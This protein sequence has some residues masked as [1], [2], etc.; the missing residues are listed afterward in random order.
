[1]FRL[2]KSY[3][4]TQTILDASSAVLN[5]PSGFLE[6]L[7]EGVQISLSE[8]PTGAAEAEFIA[9]QIVELTGGTS[10]FSIDSNVTDGTRD[11]L[12]GSLSDFAILC[13]T[14][15]QFGVVAKALRDHNL[16]YQEV[17]TIP[18]FR[19]EPFKGYF[20]L[21]GILSSAESG[22]AAALLRMKGKDIPEMRFREIA[23]KAAELGPLAYLEYVRAQL[24][25]NQP[26][27]PESWKRFLGMAEGMRDIR[28][29]LE[30]L[31]L[32]TGTDTHDR[33]MEAVSLMTLHASKGLEFECVFIAGCEEGL[34]PYSLYK[35][36]TDPEE[37][38]RLFYVGMT[39]A[40][41]LLYLTHSRSRNFHGR[42][43][44]LPVSPFVTSIKMELLKKLR[45]TP[46]KR[47]D[48]EGGQLNL[49]S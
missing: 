32:G 49:F 9:R 33:Q 39:R 44:S 22:K 12:T 40:K 28:E 21:L 7:D 36:S 43:F 41:R 35:V 24:F 19:E 37:E 1:M 10:F 23:G 3:R 4:C 29:F 15:D 2:T 34:I 6:G 48:K 11:D 18:F 8:Q 38:K 14:R 47:R 16:P 25:A 26:F 42:R 45:G 30:Y 20:G 31:T 27:N 46:P 13:R 5:R 17:G